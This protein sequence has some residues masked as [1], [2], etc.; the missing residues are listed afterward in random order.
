MFLINLDDQPCDTSVD[1]C[2]W[3]NDRGWKRIRY[4]E[5]HQDY[6]NESGVKDIDIDGGNHLKIFH[7]TADFLN[8]INSLSIRS[9]YQV[10]KPVNCSNHMARI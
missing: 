3:K 9:L 6:Q 7:S 10:Y 4:Q 8:L 5:H 2:G 1:W